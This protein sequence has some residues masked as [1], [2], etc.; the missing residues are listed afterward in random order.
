MNKT[1]LCSLLI[2]STSSW[3][4]PNMRLK[5]GEN[6]NSVWAQYCSNNPDLDRAPTP[7]Y[8]HPDVK[9]AAE[10]LAKVSEYSYYFYSGPVKMYGLKGLTDDK[11]P[12]GFPAVSGAVR[13]GRKNAHTFL[14]VLCGEFRD[15]ASMIRE[16]LNWIKN[17]Y[18]LS[19]EP[20]TK[21]DIKGNIWSQVNA[22]SYLLYLKIS[23]MVWNYK[24]LAGSLADDVEPGSMTL[25]SYV[26]DKPVDGLTICETKYIFNAYVTKLLDMS[27][28]KRQAIF[29]SIGQKE[30]AQYTAG[31]KKFELACSDEDKNYYYDFRG[32]SNFKPNSPE[33]N[34]MI[35]HASSITNN[36]K[37]LT[38]DNTNLPAGT[39]ASY[40]EK[41][42]ET[43]WN[44]ARSGLATWLFR[45]TEHDNVFSSEGQSVTILSFK[46]LSPNALIMDEPFRY[47][48]NGSAFD[49][50]VQSWSNQNLNNNDL[51]FNSTFDVSKDKKTAYE[52]IRDAVNRHT[53]WYSSGYDDGRG[54]QRSQAYSPFVASS[55]E[56]SKSDGFTAPGM[57]VNAP[58]DGCKHWM[59]VFR[60]AKENWYNVQSMA[61]NKPLD[62]DSQWFDETSF[63]TNNLADSER[64]WD[65]MGSAL[66]GEYDSI[67]YLHNITTGGQVQANCGASAP[68]LQ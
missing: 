3:A 47:K 31:Y 54:L 56:M 16:K 41:P 25:G 64:A 36:C 6:N 12:A 39:C 29:N 11:V 19:A 65:R 9:S 48:I 58:S 63:G 24:K 59:F 21:F 35:W 8:N 51:G 30:Y 28:E 50:F 44:A 14:T 68:P 62:F 7:N 49:Q 4:L 15:R 23:D 5:A 33:S 13:N 20:K 40:F 27:P 22:E 66:E 45:P 37:S 2:L 61:N 17:M 1:I 46:E 26:V 34:A 43:R 55:Y 18:V 52:R 57:T 32:D 42:F 38:Q 10:R 60:V 53:D 67:L